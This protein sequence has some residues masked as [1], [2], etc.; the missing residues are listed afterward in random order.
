MQS[1]QNVK[2][3]AHIPIDCV[4][5]GRVADMFYNS[6]IR[7]L[8]QQILDHKNTRE[9]PYYAD[10]YAC[11]G[12][13]SLNNAE[14]LFSR[15]WCG[16][17]EIDKIPREEKDKKMALIREKISESIAKSNKAQQGKAETPI[18]NAGKIERIKKEM[19]KL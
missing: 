13:F 12:A 14:E 11:R 16:I 18:P 9:S 5:F 17:P 4:E 8:P 6:G 1:S 7:E 19:I 10:M 3:V 15:Y 2:N